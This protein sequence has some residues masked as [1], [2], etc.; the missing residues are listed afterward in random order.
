MPVRPTFDV[1]EMRLSSGGGAG[2]SSGQHT[3]A[4]KGKDKGKAPFDTWQTA[5]VY[6]RAGILSQEDVETFGNDDDDDDNDDDDN[7]DGDGNQRRRAERKREEANNMAA[8]LSDNNT[9]QQQQQQQQSGGPV[10]PNSA[11]GF[12]F[13]RARTARMAGHHNHRRHTYVLK[14]IFFYDMI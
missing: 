3:R 7:D 2:A 1:D 12:K 8:L 10:S 11:A 9:S 5:M 4:D 6:R 14:Y 13:D